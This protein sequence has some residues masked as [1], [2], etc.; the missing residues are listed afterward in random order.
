MG[1][2]ALTL[3]IAAQ[4]ADAKST[5]IA[6]GQ[7]PL[8][9]PEASIALPD[10]VGRIDHMAVDLGHRH[11]F[12]AELGNG[13]VDVVDLGTRKVIHRIA[14]LRAPQGIGY[15]PKSD[16]LIVASGGDGTVRFYSG[17]N[18][19]PLGMV[20]LGD[21][22]DNLR[23]DP[24]N[25]HVIVGY[26]DGA[27]AII[28]P[29]AMA[30]L[31]E[32][33]LPAHPESFRLSGNRVFIN[34]P[35]AGQIVV[36]DL[37]SGKVLD[38]WKPV[39]LSSNFPMILDDRDEVGVVF[40]GQATLAL[41]DPTS[42]SLITSRATCGDVDDLFFDTKRKYFYVSC[43]SGAVDVIGRDQAGLKLLSH[44]QTASGARTS[45]FVPELARL[46]VAKRAGLLGSAASI[47]V[48]VTGS[49]T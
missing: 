13:T 46:F 37:D 45:L 3:G 11:L 25:G 26:G 18:F 20:A 42:G 27:L 1:L 30:K 4:A 16:R 22:A 29:V 43:G 15:E 24:R 19:A 38:T 49:G 33:P 8:L 17:R 32:I 6:N 41:F 10:T 44:I 12:V 5:S 47:L 7:L 48:F 39:H 36:A 9:T 14:G 31:S 28:D 23:I 21:D 34:V 35:D 2:A 40:R